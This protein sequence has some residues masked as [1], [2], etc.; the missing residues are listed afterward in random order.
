[1]HLLEYFHDYPPQTN[2]NTFRPQRTWTPSP[3]R[4]ISTLVHLQVLL[5]L[6]VLL[7][8]TWLKMVKIY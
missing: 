7:Q 4:E 5:L 8:N 2:P 3:H 1:M 6:T